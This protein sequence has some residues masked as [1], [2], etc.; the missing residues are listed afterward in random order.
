MEGQRSLTP[1]ISKQTPVVFLCVFSNPVFALMHDTVQW[2][3]GFITLCTNTV[4]AMT[5]V[6]QRSHNCS[7]HLQ[8]P[9][10]L[11]QDST[12]SH[13]HAPFPLAQ[14]N[15]QR[16]W[17]FWSHGR[18]TSLDEA[19]QPGLRQRQRTLRRL[20][21]MPRFHRLAQTTNDGEPWKLRETSEKRGVTAYLGVYSGARSTRHSLIH[22]QPQFASHTI[23]QVQITLLWDKNIRFCRVW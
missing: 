12:K 19:S 18:Q 3:M 15:W 20:A 5:S 11:S 16:R 9:S 1:K 6:K 8:T 23:L 2:D 10:V 22:K 7:Q 13:R 4:A 17:F 14:C 21:R